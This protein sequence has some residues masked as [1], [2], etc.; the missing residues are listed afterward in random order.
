MNHRPPDTPALPTLDSGVTLLNSDDRITGALQSLVLDH[1]L[2][3]DGSAVWVDAKGNSTTRTLA[4]VAPSMRTLERIHVARAFTPWQHQSL[5]RDL[6]DEVDDE[7]SLIVLPSFDAFYRGDDVRRSEGKRLVT[8]GLDLIGDVVDEYDVPVVVTQSRAD[9]L[10]APL[11]SAADHTVQCEMTKFGPRFAGEEFETLVY[12]VEGG[13]VQTTLAF[14]QRVLSQRHP[15]LAT[16]T[17]PEVS[18]V[19]SH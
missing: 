19:G 9:S 5:L 15:A 7:T 18:P 3:D 13:L 8:A 11:R 10:T 16:A 6:A 1:I 14:W 4:Q 2:V 12:P 17:T